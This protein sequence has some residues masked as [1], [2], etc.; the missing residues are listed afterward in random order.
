MNIPPMIAEAEIR[1]EI[2]REL[3]AVAPAGWVRIVFSAASVGGAT[4]VLV[5]AELENGGDRSLA[6]PSGTALPLSR[7]RR[8]LYEQDRG[9]WFS[10]ELIVTSDGAAEATY[11][12]DDEPREFVGLIPRLWLADQEKFPRSLENRPEWLRA[13]LAEAGDEEKGPD[14]GRLVA[15]GTELWRRMVPADAP[16]VHREVPAIG[17]VAVSHAVRGGGT[18]YVGS[19]EGVLFSSSSATE[20]QSVEVFASGRRTPWEHFRPADS[21]R[22][23]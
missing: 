21:G 9:T 10:M 14:L 6:A 1:A 7:L 17:G 18:I 11:D 23:R 16:L 19:D 3:V 8:A 20:D 4:D 15:V 5:T 13:K 2:A 22:R 12:Y